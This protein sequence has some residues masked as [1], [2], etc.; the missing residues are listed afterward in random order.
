MPMNYRRGLQ[1]V[2]AVLTVGWIAVV[3]F[4]LPS[5]RLKF[6]S[7]QPNDWTSVPGGHLVVDPAEVT[8]APSPTPPR[9]AIKQ[10]EFEGVIHEFPEDF[11]DDEIRKALTAYAPLTPEQ[12]QAALNAGF[13]PEQ[14]IEHEKTRKAATTLQAPFSESRTAK[15]AWLAGVLFLPPISGYA[16]IFLLIPWVYRGFRPASAA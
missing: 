8:S 15:A 1:R 13:T 12:Y 2:Y 9:G 10:I 14:I 3:L 16:A 6:W 4:A 7:V 5:V 11:T